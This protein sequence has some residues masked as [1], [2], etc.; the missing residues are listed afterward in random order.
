MD[1][2][3]K[4]GGMFCRSSSCHRRSSVLLKECGSG[5]GCIDSRVSVHGTTALL[6]PVPSALEQT[7]AC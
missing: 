1:C 6:V 5:S 7:W 3:G 4:T 2:A